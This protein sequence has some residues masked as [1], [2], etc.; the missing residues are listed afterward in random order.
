[1][2]GRR[3]AT[4]RFAT[5]AHATHAGLAID[6]VTPEFAASLRAAGIKVFVYTANDP[7]DIAALRAIPVDGIISDYPDRV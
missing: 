2:T 3:C 6:S 1:M 5:D 4:T 7:R